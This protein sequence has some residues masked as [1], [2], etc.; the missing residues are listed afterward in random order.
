MSNKVRGS[1]SGT[2]LRSR[3]AVLWL[4]GGRGTYGRRVTGSW[5]GTHTRTRTRTH[6]PTHTRHP[7]G[8]HSA[9]AGASHNSSPVHA[10]LLDTDPATLHPIPDTSCGASAREQGLQGK[11]TGRG[12]LS[13]AQSNPTPPLR[14]LPFVSFYMTVNRG[15]ASGYYQSPDRDL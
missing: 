9:S 15:Q 10:A 14:C 11:Q 4:N 3:G 6:A 8:F 1:R 7:S 2:G 13:P 5:A 12:R